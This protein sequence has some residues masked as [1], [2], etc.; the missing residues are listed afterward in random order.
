MAKQKK[1]NSHIKHI[2]NLELAFELAKINLGSTG[3]NPSV[4]C[5][6]ERDGSIISSGH[7]SFNGR[8]HAEFNSLKKNINFKESNIYVTLEPCSHYGK[9]PPC[10]NIIRKKG[11]KKVFYCIDDFDKRSKNKSHKILYKNKILTKKF[12]LKKR[13]FEFYESYQRF[14]SN[15]LPLIDAKIALS[16]DYFT[17]DKKNKWITNE[18]SRKLTHL[19]RTKYNALLSTSKS[20]NEDNSLL[21]CRINGLSHKSPNLIILDRN[22]KIKKNLNIFKQNINRKIFIYTKNN[23]KKKIKWLKKK[24][25]KVFLLQGMDT[26]K[27]FRILFKSFTKLGYS[28]IFIESGLTFINFLLINNFLNNIYIFKTSSNLNNNGFNNASNKY[29]K[30]IKLKNKLRVFLNG[31]NVYRER[32]N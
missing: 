13:A 5:V 10:T 8:P 16:K 2:R 25:V 1:N 30:K 9:T 19:L 22:L 6:I 24:K 29:L 27:D 14:K 28:R 23:N 21:N 31:D 12:I 15:K 17:K 20:I 4:G 26:V 18:K 3:A 11:I 7:T 32:L